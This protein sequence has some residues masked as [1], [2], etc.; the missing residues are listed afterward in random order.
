MW[1]KH[2]ISTTQRPVLVAVPSM[3]QHDGL[4]RASTLGTAQYTGC[5]AADFVE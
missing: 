1:V 3:V 4:G 5:Y 2:H